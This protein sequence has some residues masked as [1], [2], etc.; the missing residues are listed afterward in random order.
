MQRTAP[1]TAAL[2]VTAAL[3]AS[4]AAGA[5]TRDAFRVGIAGGDSGFRDVQPATVTLAAAWTPG[6]GSDAGLWRS[7]LWELNLSR[8]QPHGF[9]AGDATYS[10]GVRASLRY[11]ADDTG[12]TFLELGTG[13]MWIENPQLRETFDLGGNVHFNS[14]V[15]IGRVLGA[16]HRH[17]LAASVHHVS[18]ADLERIN[19][20]IDFFLVEYSLRF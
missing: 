11:A 3:A 1:W 19:P 17:E 6:A 5:P 13:P 16:G 18:N 14:H 7:L 20:G 8:W 2:A 15:G 4:S 10:I 9:G 12:R